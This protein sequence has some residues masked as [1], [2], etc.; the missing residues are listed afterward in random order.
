MPDARSEL[1]EELSN[2]EKKVLLTLQKLGK[3]ATP[4]QVVQK[5]GFKQLVEVM[6]A[7]SWLQSK[8]LVTI[9]EEL[10]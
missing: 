4:E 6:N 7:A 3:V 2:N 9:T 5:G 10:N 1:I 8:N